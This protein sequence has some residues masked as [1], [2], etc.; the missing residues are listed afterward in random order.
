MCVT[1]TEKFFPAALVI[2][3]NFYKKKY[4]YLDK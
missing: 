4:N 1:E 2:I 3:L